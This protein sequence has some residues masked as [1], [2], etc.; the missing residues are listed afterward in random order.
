M[1]RDHL[2]LDRPPDSGTCPGSYRD[3][4]L[5]YEEAAPRRSV[6]KATL[7]RL[8]ASEITVADLE[9]LRA[10]VDRGE[11]EYR[12]ARDAAFRDRIVRG[13]RVW[14]TLGFEA[15]FLAA[16]LSFVSWPLFASS[17]VAW[18]WRVGLAPFLLFLPYFLGYAPMTFTNGPSGGFVYPLYL[19]LASISL[20][21]VPCSAADQ[22]LW[23][24]LPPALSALSQVPGNPS[25]YSYWTCVGPASSLLFGMLL[26]S[27]LALLGFGWSK[28][29]HRLVAG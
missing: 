2:E 26:V 21:L 18:Y 29:R 24:R 1:V 4:C 10:R 23:E 5:I 28:V 9:R 20:Q 25:A 17:R 15:A 3:N 14:L 19:A 12:L 27:F 7:T 16:W 13:K 11:T 6:C 22:F 8:P